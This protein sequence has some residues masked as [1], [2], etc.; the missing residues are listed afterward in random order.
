[1][2][3]PLY[4]TMSLFALAIVLFAAVWFLVGMVIVVRAELQK[5]DSSSFA[6]AGQGAGK[7]ATGLVEAYG[8]EIAIV[9]VLAVALVL[10]I[11]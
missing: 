7:T 6:S 10:G 9:S 11:A 5:S 8:L 1:M 2:D 4:A 3:A